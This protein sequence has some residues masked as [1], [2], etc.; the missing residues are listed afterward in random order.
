VDGGLP[1]RLQ[2]GVSL[3][4]QMAGVAPALGKLVDLA[5][6]GLP[7]GAG[8]GLL[9]GAPGLDLVDQGLA[10]RLCWADSART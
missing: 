6:H 3:L 7:V 8:A 9:R 4:G 5:A 1:L 10:L 2:L